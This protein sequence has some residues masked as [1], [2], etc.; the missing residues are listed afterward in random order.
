MVEQGMD[1][2]TKAYRDIVTMM[3]KPDGS[4]TETLD[5][6]EFRYQPERRCRVCS[7]TDPR[8][9]L[10]NGGQVKQLVDDLLLYPKD[11]AGIWRVIEPMMAQ[12][13]HQHKI[14]YKSIRTHQKRH[15]PFDA[16]ALRGMVERW[17]NEK[18]MSI[19]DAS[20]RMILTEEAWLEA[21]AQKGWEQL[22]NGTMWPSWAETQ[23]AFLR[24]SQL[25]AQAEG[26]FDKVTLLAQLNTIIE[27][28]REVVP[29]EMWPQIVARI[30]AAERPELPPPS[31]EEEV[32][33][34]LFD[35]LLTEGVTDG[36]R[37]PD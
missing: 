1:R 7:A 6:I 18:G 9:G 4:I 3:P 22:A 23:T 17:A 14:S 24:I 20:G 29:P 5:G 25:K 21:T 28:V 27:A 30:E 36:S 37:V 8:K 2:R 32:S 26:E 15:L 31:S 33:D 10:Q 11:I 16:L 34:E 35:E 13:P 12:W 19:I